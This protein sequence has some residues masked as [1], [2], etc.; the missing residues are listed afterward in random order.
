MTRVDR[1]FIIVWLFMFLFILIFV[2][3]LIMFSTIENYL[4]FEDK[5]YSKQLYDYGITCIHNLF[6]EYEIKQLR[7]FA[8]TNNLQKIKTFVENSRTWKQTL[9]E[10]LGNEYV[11][12]DYVFLIKKSC[13]HTCHRDYNNQYYNKD[14]QYPSYTFIIYLEDMEKCLDVIPG[15]Q[16]S[17]NENDYKNNIYKCKFCSKTFTRNYSLSR[18]LKTCKAKKENFDLLKMYDMIHLLKKENNEIK[19]QQVKKDEEYQNNTNKLNKE[20]QYLKNKPNITITNNSINTNNIQL[21]NYGKE[22]IDYLITPKYIN[23]IKMKSNLLGLLD[24]QNQKYCHPEHK[25]NWNIGVTNLKHDI[26]KVYNNNKWETRKISEVALNN[27]MRGAIEL[28]EN[29]E[30]IA[31]ESGRF[32][33]SNGN[34]LDKYERDLFDSYDKATCDDVKDEFY[35]KKLKEAVDKHKQHIYDHT[36]LYK[37]HFIRRWNAKKS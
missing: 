25:E 26:C 22:N 33:D 7:N 18:H 31:Y 12:I 35:V 19:I 4:H 37:E 34:I 10:I 16:K 29:M 32:P 24:Y 28:Y 2:Y 17:E 20:I 5:N 1:P 23:K 30:N 21:N 8:N 13:I 27:F 14:Q 15:S 11:I 3:F 36:N 6:N 9:N